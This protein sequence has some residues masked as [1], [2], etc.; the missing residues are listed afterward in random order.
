MQPAKPTAK[1]RSSEPINFWL[2]QHQYNGNITWYY[3]CVSEYYLILPKCTI[4]LNITD[5]TQYYWYYSILLNITQYYSILLILLN[6]TNITQYNMLK[7]SSSDPELLLD[8]TQVLPILLNIT[9]ITNIT[10]CYQ[11]Y[12]S[13]CTNIIQYYISNITQYS[14]GGIQYQYY[15]ILLILPNIT[16][17]IL[18]NIPNPQNC[19][20]PIQ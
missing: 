1:V 9:I 13:I 10:Y 14:I 7:C 8:I 3:S 15:S 20:F 17:S 19:D 6:I 16:Y 18:L 2:F 5:I 4:L 11:Y 12:K